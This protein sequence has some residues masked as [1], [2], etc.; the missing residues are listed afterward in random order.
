MSKATTSRVIDDLRFSII[1]PCLNRRDD[2]RAAL[3]SCIQQTFSK[4][5]IVVIDDCSELPLA[6]ICQEFGDARISC[7]RSSVNIGPARSRNI[8]IARSRGEYVS[9]LDSDDLYLPHR[10]ELLD[11]LIRSNSEPSDILIHRQKRVISAEGLGLMM[12]K[13]LPSRDQRLD[14][15]VFLYGNWLQTNSFVVRRELAQTIKFDPECALYE[16]TKYIIQCW[17]V[18]DNVVATDEVLSI[19]N[20]FRTNLRV[21]RHRSFGRIQS[22]LA[23]TE[24]HCSQRANLAFQ[25]FAC[26]EKVFRKQ[27]LH[28]I[29]TIWEGYRA[30]TPVSRCFIYLCRSMF[31]SALV[32]SAV[33]SARR[34]LLS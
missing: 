1:I 10:L 15:Y 27:P 4:F 3:R 29:W 28:V 2:L 26:G 8:G 17:L 12:P 19:F 14:E 22:M 5:E 7:Y 16:D 9:F 25:A 34:K 32:D 20:D 13:N 18:S 23:F 30:G 21:S 24:E 31:G 11:R 6:D 33:N